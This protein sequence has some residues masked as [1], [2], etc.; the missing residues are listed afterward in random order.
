MGSQKAFNVTLSLVKEKNNITKSLVKT[1]SCKVSGSV[2]CDIG[3]FNTRYPLNEEAIHY[4]QTKIASIEFEE[5]IYGR[6]TSNNKTKFIRKYCTN[7]AVVTACMQV[8]IY[9]QFIFKALPNSCYNG[10]CH[11]TF[12]L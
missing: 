12:D 3:H 5:N 2:K 10:K 6:N 8:T 11:K 7:M 9:M 1:H 4:N